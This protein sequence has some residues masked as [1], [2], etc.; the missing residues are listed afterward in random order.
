VEEWRRSKIIVVCPGCGQEKGW[1]FAEATY[2]RA[3][4][5]EPSRT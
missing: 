5:K 3:L 1:R 4:L 2:V